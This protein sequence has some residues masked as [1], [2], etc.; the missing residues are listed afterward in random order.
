MLL[1]R[2]RKPIRLNIACFVLAILYLPQIVIAD[3]MAII[4]SQNEI[5]PFE[6]DNLEYWLEIGLDDCKECEAAKEYI[7][8]LISYSPMRNKSDIEKLYNS[9]EENINFDEIDFIALNYYNFII[10][11]LNNDYI[12]A[13]KY[14]QNINDKI[15][16]LFDEFPPSEKYI[17]ILENMMALSSTLVE[18]LNSL[19]EFYGEIDSKDGKSYLLRTITKVCLSEGVF[20]CE[21][22]I[23]LNQAIDAGIRENPSDELHIL[24]NLISLEKITESKYDYPI[25]YNTKIENLIIEIDEIINRN[26][27][28]YFQKFF[29]YLP[30]ELFSENYSNKFKNVLIHRNLEI[31]TNYPSIELDSFIYETANLYNATK[32][33]DDSL[34][35]KTHNVLYDYASSRIENGFSEIYFDKQID[36]LFTLKDTGLTKTNLDLY[37][38]YKKKSKNFNKNSKISTSFILSFTKSLLVQDPDKLELPL[39]D[40]IKI[41]ASSNYEI[42][43]PASAL[44]LSELIRETEYSSTIFTPLLIM[45]E[46]YIKNNPNILD[47]YY[48]YINDDPI[49]I[50]KIRD[51]NEVY[52]KIKV[53]NIYRDKIS[54]LEHVSLI[55][56]IRKVV[57]NYGREAVVD[58]ELKFEWY[59]LNLAI[60]SVFYKDLEL[61]NMVVDTFDLF[62]SKKTRRDTIKNDLFNLSESSD[63]TDLDRLSESEIVI[64][65]RDLTG[66]VGFYLKDYIKELSSKCE[67]IIVAVTMGHSSLESARSHVRQMNLP[68]IPNLSDLIECDSY[69]IYGSRLDLLTGLYLLNL[70]NRN[71]ILNQKM[72]EIT[73]HYI[74]QVRSSSDMF[75][76]QKQLPPAIKNGIAQLTLYT[77]YCSVFYEYKEHKTSYFNELLPNGIF[78]DFFPSSKFDENISSCNRNII[79]VLDMVSFSDRTS[80]ILSKN[81]D[82]ST[83]QDYTEFSDSVDYFDKLVR[84]ST[85]EKIIENVSKIYAESVLKLN[86]VTRLVSSD[87]ENFRLSYSPSWEDLIGLQD[88]IMDE[89]I[90]VIH[91]AA[92]YLITQTRISSYSFKGNQFNHLLASSSRLLSQSSPRQNLPNYDYE[93]AHEIYAAIFEPFEDQLVNI[94]NISV[95][96][97]TP[98]YGLPFN[99]LVTDIKTKAFAYENYDFVYWPSLRSFYASKL[100]VF[101]KTL[102]DSFIGIG[103]PSLAGANRNIRDVN[104]L[105]GKSTILPTNLLEYFGPLPETEEELNEI[106][107]LYNSS[108]VL[109]GNYATEDQI[110][111]VDFSKFSTVMF[112]THGVLSNEIP[113]LSEPAIILSPSSISIANDGLL[114]ASEISKLDFSASLIILSAC[115][116]NIDR[117]RENYDLNGLSTAFLYAGARSL[118][119]TNWQVETN[120]IKALT[121]GSLKYMREN[122]SS[123]NDGIDFAIKKL[124][125]DSVYDHPAYWGPLTVIG[126]SLY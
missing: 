38:E 64:Y 79:P 120:S 6:L 96:T 88:K 4:K 7:L 71:T 12:A 99:I 10:S 59:L 42:F 89:A 60:Q 51:L 19:V 33:I 29:E 21:Y 26:N 16:Y 76:K 23:D 112:S 58:Y 36:T 32:S 30:S 95:I 100:S 54:R 117:S 70:E 3:E 9:I 46:N 34:R 109:V 17:P 78:E 94:E 49:T 13:K 82:L 1:S 107:A 72:F 103:N 77:Y 39:E 52:T 97:D 122:N 116:T 22:I 18:S 104:I 24:H 40:L 66:S 43:T 44:L 123:L 115:N 2:N 68:E 8:N 56:D 125:D 101:D 53:A 45:E 73:N 48:N 14:E 62:S 84:D 20:Y 102:E 75:V 92:I 15:G 41:Y 105:S 113:G 5:A 11:T 81:I 61:T 69:Q 111:N 121:T 57:E 63:I 98:L 93:L 35:K 47:N 65:A 124:R 91:P 87:D 80:A 50:S 118:L 74:E 110:R 85:Q 119:V 37:S 55:E 31:I 126:E 108:E 28:P 83:K 27:S 106:A 86:E 67:N 90:V 114:T 25:E